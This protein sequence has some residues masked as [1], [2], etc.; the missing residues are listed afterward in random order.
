MKAWLR[1]RQTWQTDRREGGS[2]PE[3]GSRREEGGGRAG[4]KLTATFSCKIAC[5]SWL[6]RCCLTKMRIEGK[7][8]AFWF[9]WHGTAISTTP[10]ITSHP[11]QHSLARHSTAR[12][13]TK[14]RNTAQHNTAQHSTTQ[15][16]TALTTNLGT[17]TH[18][19]SPCMWL[20]K[21]LSQ[22]PKVLFVL[23]KFVLL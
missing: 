21:F 8:V 5:S 18:T 17:H 1:D 3:G 16:S 13:G 20:T 23:T 9:P 19:R 6:C 22:W 4:R 7:F 2:E 11:A 12:H 14:P 10:L 15:R